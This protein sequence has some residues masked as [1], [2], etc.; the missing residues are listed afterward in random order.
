MS[1]LSDQIARAETLLR[2]RDIKIVVSGCGCC[3]SPAVYLEIEGEPIIFDPD[4]KSE[5]LGRRVQDNARL[6][7]TK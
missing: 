5:E 4:E 3:G 2:N 7:N 6:N 1:V